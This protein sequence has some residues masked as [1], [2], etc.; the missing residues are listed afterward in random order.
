MIKT[1]RMYCTANI[2]GVFCSVYI[3]FKFHVWLPEDVASPGWRS[4]D[5]INFDRINYSTFLEDF[6]EMLDKNRLQM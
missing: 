5:S 6:E 2:C 4:R 1:P 3:V